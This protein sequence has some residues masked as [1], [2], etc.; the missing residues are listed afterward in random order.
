[1]FTFLTGLMIL[2]TGLTGCEEKIMPGDGGNIIKIMTSN[3]PAYGEA[4]AEYR[5]TITAD[6]IAVP[7]VVPLELDGAFLIGEVILVAGTDRLFTIEVFDTDG[8]AVYSGS[9][10][11]SVVRGQLIT[12]DI[13]LIPVAPL[14]K[15][16][17][18]YDEKFM[19]ES[20]TVDIN[21]YNLVGLSSAAF[22]FL[23]GS[24]DDLVWVDSV[25]KGPDYGNEVLLSYQVGI[26]IVTVWIDLAFLTGDIVDAN[27]DATMATVFL[28]T[29]SDTQLLVDTADLQIS[30]VSLN[31]ANGDLIDP[32]P[33]K[34]YLDESMIVLTKPA[35]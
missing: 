31:R 32:F 35:L 7:I 9:T 24:T 15:I 27:G 16:T 18:R 26:N 22:Y 4:F 29:H 23:Y 5:L 33:D 21:C 12:L 3:R 19:G 25:V 2:L 17:P 28:S 1:M 30:P 20:F 8:V 34:V 6:D 11:A 14:M 13:D 10:S